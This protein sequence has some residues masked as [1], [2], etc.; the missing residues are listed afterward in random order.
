[1]ATCL[2]GQVAAV[3]V[4]GTIEDANSKK[5]LEGA[6]VNVQYTRQGTV[7]DALGNFEIAGLKTGEQ[8]LV[9]EKEGY[10]TLEIIVVVRENED[11][12]VGTIELSPINQSIGLEDQDIIPVITLSESDLAGEGVSNQN[13]SGMLFASRDVFINTAAFNLGSARFRIR[14]YDSENTTV[15]LNGIP[16]NDLED[17]RV[18][19]SAWGGLNDVTR[20]Q[21]ISLGLGAAFT[22][23]GGVGGVTQIDTRASS[24]RKTLRFSY[25][26]SNRS[27]RNRLMAT[28]NSGPLNGGWAVSLSG[29]RRWAEEGYAEGTF[30]DG[31][32]YF[33][34]I[35][36]LIGKKHLL[37]LTFLGAPIK[38]GKEGAAVQEIYDITDNNY[39]NPYWGYQNGKKRNSRIADIHE[40]MAILRYD[41][42]INPSSKLTAAAS[43][44]FGHNA[45]TALDWFNARD[46]RPDYYQRLPSYARGRSTDSLA[47]LNALTTNP[48]LLQIDWQGIYNANRFSPLET[49]EN[50]NG[51]GEAVTGQRASFILEERRFDAKRLSANINFQTSL[52]RNLTLNLGTGYQYHKGET[53]KVVRDLLGADFY[54]DIDRFADDQLGQQNNVDVP[55]RLVYEGDR[56]GY[57]YD[58][59][60][61]KS[62]AWGQLLYSLPKLDAFIA[63]NIDFTEYWRVGN[64]RNGKF[65]FENNSFGESE[66]LNFTSYGV[67]GGFTYK[68]DGRNYFYARGMYGT[69]A[70]YA[71]YA[72]SSPRTR[73]EFVDGLVTEKITSVEAGYDFRSPYFK[74]KLSGY[75]SLFEDGVDIQSFFVIDPLTDVGDFIYLTLNGI[76]RQH[77]GIEAAVEARIYRGLTA[78]V[79]AAVGQY[80][81]VS[82]PQARIYVDSERFARG[83]SRTIYMQ[84]FYVSGTP[85][86]AYSL[87]L[88]YSGKEFWFASLNFNYF[89][90]IWIDF[91]PIRRTE[92]AVADIP[93][94][95]ELFQST[96]F[97]EKAPAGYT[98]DLFGGKSFK[99]ADNYFLNLTVGVNNLLNNQGIITGGYEQGRF[100][101]EPNG[102]NR[103]PNRYY[104]MYG[105]N[106]FFNATFRIEL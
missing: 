72:F 46:P 24:Q 52:N 56:F 44:Q 23:F 9:I 54:V 20:Y 33:A 48:D 99:L 67:K 21:E 35:D 78:N 28:Y 41:W 92:A 104:Y 43:Y 68:I 39:Y 42:E 64:L 81:Y 91:N 14:G 47:I 87:G 36:K 53:F 19:W 37:N 83:D 97:Q 106:Y 30:Y 69:R 84:N 18:Y 58:I 71:R 4:Y 103:F 2:L 3:S 5:D 50:A 25:A 16:T 74:A 94:D 40:P 98:L 49:I 66:K 90:D 10:A 105:L 38:R 101:F 73:N 26:S 85:Q 80:T 65:P 70:P 13:I 12:N 82:R 102:D 75:Y 55:N 15:L 95:S 29:S 45:S 32:S 96:I 61:V 57:D 88:K 7:T 11:N 22:S 63:G 86:Q 8:V 77:F 59:N 27:Y 76:D 17:G 89:D 34:S 6:F 79:V 93:R 60:I 1:M 51:S 62:F 31:W 100:E